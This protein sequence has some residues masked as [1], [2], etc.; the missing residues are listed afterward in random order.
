V[1]GRRPEPGEGQENRYEKLA[2]KKRLASS[3]FWDALTEWLWRTE[4]ELYKRRIEWQ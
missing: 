2:Q 3:P 1:R 4:R